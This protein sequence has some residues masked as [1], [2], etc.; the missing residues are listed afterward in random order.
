MF[1]EYEGEDIFLYP[2]EKLMLANEGSWMFYYV[3]QETAQNLCEYAI[4]AAVVKKCRYKENAE[5]ACR[6]YVAADDKKGH[7]KVLEY[8]IEN[9][10]IRHTAS[11]KLF[12]IGFKSTDTEE[13]LFKLSD[14]VEL[15]TG[16]ILSMNLF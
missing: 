5:G 2:Q 11:G 16:S 3:D 9:D 6:F 10:L 1:T 7:H 12:N 8:F 14:F 4:E 15:E 13:V